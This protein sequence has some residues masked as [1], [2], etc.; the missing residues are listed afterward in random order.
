MFSG[1]PPELQAQFL[2]DHAVLVDRRK[3]GSL[4]A[5]SI[6]LGSMGMR[7]IFCTLAF[8]TPTTYADAI[9]PIES[10]DVGILPADAMHAADYLAQL[11]AVVTVQQLVRE[12]SRQALAIYEYLDRN[13]GIAVLDA[14]HQALYLHLSLRLR[15]DGEG[16]KLLR[17]SRKLYQSVSRAFQC[18][19]G[20]NVELPAAADRR[21]LRSLGQLLQAECML[22]PDRGPSLFD[23]L[24]CK[25]QRASNRNDEVSAI[26][27]A[28]RGESLLTG[29][30]SVLRQ[31]VQF[32]QILL[33]TDRDLSPEEQALADT[34][35]EIRII[36]VEPDVPFGAAVNTAL[37]E[38]VGDFVM[39]VDPSDWCV[40]QAVERQ[41]ASLHRSKRTAVARTARMRASSELLIGKFG[42]WR[43]EVY[44]RTILFRRRVVEDLGYFDEVGPEAIEE[45][46]DRTRQPYGKGAV[47]MSRAHL[48]ALSL[49]DRAEVPY[50]EAEERITT[51]WF[52]AYKSA[53]W[54]WHERANANGG[55]PYLAAHP[56][57][58]PFALPGAMGAAAPER[59][60]DLVFASDW[61]PYGGPA[62]SMMEEINAALAIGLRVGVMN[63]EA[64][65]M[66]TPETRSLCGPVQELIN[67]GAI[68]IVI[69]EDDVAIDTLVIRYPLVL[70]FDRTFEF[71][72]SVRQVI[73]H[74]N[75]PPHEA[76][77]S[78]LRYFTTDC[79][80]HAAQ[81]FGVEPVWAAQ[82]PQA[83]KSLVDAVPPVARP[84]A[85]TYIPGI[86]DANDRFLRRDGFRSDIPVIGRHSRDYYTKWPG[87]TDTLLKVYPD[88]P[89]YDVR[90]MG[91]TLS[92]LDMLGGALPH[93]W[94]AYE[95]DE[96]DVDDFLFQLD[97][98]V[99]FPN[100]VRIEAFGRAILE[101]MASG[102]VVILPEVFR[103]TFGEGALYCGPDGVLPMIDRLYTDLPAYRRQSRLGQQFVKDH[104]SYEWY[105]DFLKER[106][107][108][109]RRLAASVERTP[110]APR[111]T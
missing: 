12:D 33:V 27:P 98:W 68:D 34:S 25:P 92:I 86:L 50:A 62:K 43:P 18:N 40:P 83:G 95:Y 44:S 97:F 105:Q 37:K 31:T 90:T 41:L 38:S 111:T 71:A 108:A 32:Q 72:G 101:A 11:A 52:P 9:A 49:D 53:Y 89:N 17:R 45:F 30:R 82:G 2:N 20:R 16:R 99:Y 77:G 19:L 26:V 61:R 36:P 35:E 109:P 76:D 103:S 7:D 84:L 39:L 65:R 59:E 15:G 5:T 63:L 42:F 54:R 102:C 28:L 8:A 81:W 78:D 29:L 46:V 85:D 3:P 67:S 88:D 60:Y 69:P 87:D 66:M 13:L 107:L 104:F 24:E 110:E 6:R 23:Q 21:W 96:T 10:G 94:I 93:N 22:V 64:V 73:I 70:Q 74:A 4:S 58:R 75:Q 1:V 47:S 14:Q 57:E 79:E 51:S 106:V 48:L 56:D 100:E 55:T 91:G 80:K